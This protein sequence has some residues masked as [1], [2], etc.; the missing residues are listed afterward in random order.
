VQHDEEP[1]EY[2]QDKLIEKMMRHHG[3]APSNMC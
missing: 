2:K 3:V 1:D